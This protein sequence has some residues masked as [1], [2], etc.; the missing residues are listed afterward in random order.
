[1]TGGARGAHGDTML[2]QRRP[3]GRG[4]AHSLSQQKPVLAV[5]SRGAAAASSCGHTTGGGDRRID[6]LPRSR[7]RGCA[8]ALPLVHHG[9]ALALPVVPPG[10]APLNRARLLRAACLACLTGFRLVFFKWTIAS[11]FWGVARPRGRPDPVPRHRYR[12]REHGRGSRRAE[13]RGLASVRALWGSEHGGGSFR[14][15]KY[16][17]FCATDMK[18]LINKLIN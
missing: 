2:L 15:Y 1:M 12:M 7:R 16:Q 5:E 10:K 4:S 18:Q 6:A 9:L 17:N 3:D 8:A 14:H 11:V 13:H